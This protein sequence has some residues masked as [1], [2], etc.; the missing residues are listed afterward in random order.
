[1]FLADFASNCHRT[2]PDLQTSCTTGTLTII[3]RS[4]EI[5]SSDAS[6]DARQFVQGFEV[7]SVPHAAKCT[8]RL[9]YHHSCT[10]H[11]TGSDRT[12]DHNQRRGV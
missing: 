5:F 4:R 8:F 2:L 10:Q 7:L 1:M 6:L 12:D 9:I 11:Y 3:Q